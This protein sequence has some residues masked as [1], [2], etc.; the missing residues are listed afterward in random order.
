MAYPKNRKSSS[1]AGCNKGAPKPLLDRTCNR[2]GES[3]KGYNGTRYCS[4]RCTFLANVAPQENG[5]W[6][7]T[8]YAPKSGNRAGYGEF[9]FKSG[10]RMLAHRASMLLLKGSEPGK[11]CVLHRCDNPPCVNPEHLFLGTS[12]DNMADRNEKGRQAR[13]EGHASAK[14][15]EED[16][17]AIRCDQRSN[18]ELASI[19]GVFETTIS[20]ARR[21]KTW[22]HI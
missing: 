13:G 7:W 10:R 1:R 17:R 8:G 5:C 16:V 20:E 19:Y 18:R 3:Y 22:K 14:L 21:R 9:D 2:C 6:L 4:D 11:Q 12:G 15:T